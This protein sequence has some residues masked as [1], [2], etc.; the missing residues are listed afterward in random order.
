MKKLREINLT[1]DTSRV[2]S[3]HV[4]GKQPYYS[5]FS[6]GMT[7]S[8][9]SSYSSLVNSKKVKIDLERESEESEDTEEEEDLMPENILKYRVRTSSG[10]SLN[11]T[12]G[13]INENVDSKSLKI[14]DDMEEVHEGLITDLIDSI[15]SIA[16]ITPIPIPGIDQGIAGIEYV[17]GTI[18]QFAAG[19]AISKLSQVFAATRADKGSITAVIS[20]LS[21]IL[22]ALPTMFS[23]P[24]VAIVN[25]ITFDA[26]ECIGNL[27]TILDKSPTKKDSM[28]SY[29]VADVAKELLGDA[30]PSAI[31]T[32]D[33]TEIVDG[34]V[35]SIRLVKNL[36]E[37]YSGT[38]KGEKLIEK[39]TALNP[40][41]FKGE[42]NTDYTEKAVS[43]VNTN[44]DSLER[45]VDRAIAA[46]MNEGDYYG[47]DEDL[48]EE[49]EEELDEFSGAGAAGG[50]SAPLGKKANGKTETASQRAS[51]IKAANIY[52]EH[53]EHIRRLQDWHIKTAGRTR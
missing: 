43:P 3:P 12:L 49:L 4:K 17:G 41:A 9:S 46:Q 10:Y 29:T 8:A 52:T 16:G 15:Q 36:L 5:G 30:I 34:I 45:L 13:A 23:M 50:V 32:L 28:Y 1:V 37:L 31:E 48:E 20:E 25:K 39:Y 14:L 26:I 42:N 24:V 22:V 33:P 40:D 53:V 6:G 21:P 47:I 19:N 51:R 2:S 7:D 18:A 35:G 44:S 27:G 38:A 11:E